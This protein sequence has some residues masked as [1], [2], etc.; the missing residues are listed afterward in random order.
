ME[1]FSKKKLFHVLTICLLIT[2]E[3]T[4]DFGNQ[5]NLQIS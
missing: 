3:P 5:R 1:Q 4:F 2:Q